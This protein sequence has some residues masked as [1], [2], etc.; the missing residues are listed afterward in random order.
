MYIQALSLS[1]AASALHTKLDFSWHLTEEPF[2]PRSK[3][4][5]DDLAF[6]SDECE[7][8]TCF[9]R[10]VYEHALVVEWGNGHGWAVRGTDSFEP[11]RH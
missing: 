9:K 4:Y 10:R 7:G 1:C 11:G 3:R 8:D 5:F 2:T 6:M